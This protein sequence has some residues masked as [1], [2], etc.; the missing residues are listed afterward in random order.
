MQ[1]SKIRGL[2]GKKKKNKQSKLSGFVVKHRFN[3][4]VVSFGGNHT[5]NVML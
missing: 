5:H 2:I 3:E 4:F 1:F